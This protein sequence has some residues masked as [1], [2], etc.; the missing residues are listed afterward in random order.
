MDVETWENDLDDIKT[1]V[2]SGLVSSDDVKG[3]LFSL[4]DG[5]EGVNS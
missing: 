1:G 5:I 4:T 2:T 3:L